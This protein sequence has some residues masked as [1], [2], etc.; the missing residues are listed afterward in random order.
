MKAKTRECFWWP[1]IAAAIDQKRAQCRQC[2][3]IMQTMVDSTEAVFGSYVCYHKLL[4]DNTDQGGQIY[5][6]GVANAPFSIS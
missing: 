2:N 3:M 4:Y 5:T 6:E 1:G